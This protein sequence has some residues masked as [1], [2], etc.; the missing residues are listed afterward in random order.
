M[1]V[2]NQLNILTVNTCTPFICS[3]QNL[4]LHL[5]TVRLAR[6]NKHQQASFKS[7]Q[8]MLG[9]MRQFGHPKQAK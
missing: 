8:D 2:N 7:M 4:P 6:I 9:E 3:K 1:Q 5:I